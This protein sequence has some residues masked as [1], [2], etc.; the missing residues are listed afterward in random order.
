MTIRSLPG[1][2][3]S[4]ITRNAGEL[5]GPALALFAFLMF[6]L[7][8]AVVK[9]LAVRYPA[10]EIV[11]GN[12]LVMLA[13]VAAMTL[14]RGGAGQLRTS[15]PALQLL[16][17]LAATLS[18]TAAFFAFSQIPLAD[19][20]AIIFTTPLLV[21]LLSVPF[22]GE[23][24]GWRRTSAVLVG[25]LGVVIMLQPGQGT[26]GAGNLAA[27]IAAGGAA[28]GIIA[29]RKLAAT[30]STTSIALYSNLTMVLA[31]GLPLPFYGVMPSLPDLGLFVLSGALGSGALLALINAYRMAPAALIAPFQYSQMIWG[32]LLGILLF[33]DM[34]GWPVLIGGAVV[35]ASG[36][37][38][39]HRQRTVAA[40]RR[41][42]AP[43]AS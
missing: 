15:R 6:S 1:A 12:G 34:P 40:Q 25:F 32:M 39:L 27:L 37:F 7:M 38:T 5:K 28:T 30:E 3:L 17:G 19:A 41:A 22:L 18:A 8:D 9:T 14:R 2:D 26:L 20:Y 31:L 35:A 36:L 42:E 4:F 23:S 11:L 43:G 21:T 29:M 10:P 33:G 24:V 16:R 13:V